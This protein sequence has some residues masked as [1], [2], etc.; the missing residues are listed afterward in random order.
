[1]ERRIR[2]ITLLGQQAANTS[3]HQ[4]G[5]VLKQIREPGRWE[6]PLLPSLPG[7]LEL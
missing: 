4:G 1:M 2:R 7:S 6:F 3:Q 5:G